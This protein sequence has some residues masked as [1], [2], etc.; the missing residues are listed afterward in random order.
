MEQVTGVV[1][2]ISKKERKTKRGDAFVYSFKLDNDEWFNNGFKDPGVNK[3]D[4]VAVSYVEGEYG[5]DVKS[6][7]V[8][9]GGSGSQ[10][11]SAG[12]RSGGNGDVQAAIIR[13]NCVGNA[14]ELVA[15]VHQGEQMEMG[16]AVAATLKAAAVLE[17]YCNGTL[18]VPTAESSEENAE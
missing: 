10:A 6:I 13:Q 11:T 9:S 18:N 12:S 4:T 2:A 8:T 17:K 1:K 7:S 3:G 5:N 16:E 15:F 14:R